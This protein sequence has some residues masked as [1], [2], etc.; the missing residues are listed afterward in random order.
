LLIISLSGIGLISA[1]MFMLANA[2]GNMEPIGWSIA[3]ISGLVAGV[4]FPPDYLPPAIQII[5]NFLPQTYAIESLREILLLGKDLA[6]P[7]IQFTIFI[8]VIFSIILL[9]IGL[10]LFN[11]GIKKGEKDGSL[12]RWI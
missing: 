1:S 3:T 7:S 2:K 11:L 12:A 8:L 10:Y 6:E 9:P 5:S 4:Y